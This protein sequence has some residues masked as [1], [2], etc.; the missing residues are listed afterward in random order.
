MD[1]HFLELI[2][3]AST[4]LPKD[5]EDRISKMLK[6]EKV[7]SQAENTLNRILENVALARQN[8]TPICQDTGTLIFK[9]KKPTNIRNAE[10]TSSIHKAC[11]A[12]TEK[13]YLRPNAVDPVTSKNSGNNIG[14]G[15]PYIH[16]DEWDEDELEVKLML[17]GGGSENVSAQYKLP[18]ANLGAGRDLKG[19]KKCLIDTCMNAQ[20]KGC[21]PGILGVGIGGDRGQSYLLAKSALTRNLDS[22]NPDPALAEIEEGMFDKINNLGIG[23]MG[24]G[25]KTTILGV[26]ASKMHRHPACY[27]VTVAYMCWA[28]RKKTMI[29]KEN[30][31]NIF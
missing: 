27:F 5:V 19:V 12:A 20:G 1:K 4:D 6:L 9:I 16:I 11:M 26:L 3:L 18:D 13:Q 30:D 15:Q 21:A 8:S 2:R 23:P 22:K 7:S 24:F 14:V 29:L 28:Y 31:V 25:G 10:L 17:K